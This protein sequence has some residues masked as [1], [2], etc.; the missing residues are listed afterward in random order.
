[1]LKDLSK[2]KTKWTIRK[3]GSEESF[4]QDTPFAVE[5]VDGNI[6]LNEG[7][8]LLQTLLTGGAGTAFN[9]ANSFLGVGD[10]TQAAAA[11]DTGLVAAT[12]KLYKGMEPTYPQISA[13]TTT[14]RA[15]FQSADANYAWNE[16]TV[17]NGG[18]DASINLNRKVSAQGTKVA[19]QVWTLDLSIT[20]S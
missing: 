5:D 10:S 6:L 16:F 15:V 7:I 1:M 11:T 19:G 9:N 18:S 3:Y 17:A 13:Q 14:W 4:R 20:W 12:N 2:A 8:T